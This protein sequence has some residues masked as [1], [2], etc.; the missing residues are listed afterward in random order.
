MKKISLLLA[1]LLAGTLAF[2][3]CE[4]MDDKEVPVYD[5]IYKGMNLYYYWKDNVPAL[6]D[7]NFQNQAD[8][9]AYLQGYGSPEELF[10]SLLFRPTGIDAVDKWSIIIS[11][12]RVLENALQG[13]VK[14]N[15]V[16]FGLRY[17][18]DTQ[19]NVF[20]Y[21]R[22]ILPGSDAS[23]KNIQRGDLFYA[24]NGTP[25]NN[26]NYQR[27]LSADTY[28]L[29]LADYVD[30]AI[31]PNGEQV[32]LTRTEYAENPVYYHNTYTQNGHTFGYLM[33]NGF[34][35]NYDADLNAAFGDLKA[36]GITD[37]VLDLRYNSGGSVRTA[38]YLA[39]MIT[40]QYTGQVFTKEQWNSRLQAH[41]EANNPAQLQELF[42]AQLSNGAAI[43]H[44]NLNRVYVLV[45]Q[46]SASASELL[47][48]CLEPY[49]DVVVIGETTTGK[50]VAST[51]LYDSPNF[52]RN[53]RNSSHFYAMQPIVLKTLNKNNFGDYAG[54]IAPDVS[55]PENMANL[56]VLGDVNE[57][58]FAAAITGI[59]GGGRAPQFFRESEFKSFRDSKNM[60]RFG[61]EMYIEALPDG[62][63]VLIKPLQ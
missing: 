60:R 4:D 47:I 14:S 30:G 55:L 23:T 15:G 10:R 52:G 6:R 2:Q 26:E 50:N 21:V 36:Q 3:S 61:T 45:T 12:Y 37:L 22:Y 8:L 57:P 35:S 44:L 25:L 56:G 53:D 51:T 32:V 59:T 1:A 46:S 28:T 54:G 62:A 58:L 27:L 24:V 40:G 39:S 16:E 33:Y 63:D 31:V 9:N 48:N 49:I 43:N 17:T 18:D 20:G 13:V 34:Y 11:D 7:D 19:T 29:N 5:F 38:G 42:S 41:F